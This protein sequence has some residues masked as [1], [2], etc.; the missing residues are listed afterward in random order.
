MRN[1]AFVGV[2][3]GFLTAVGGT[4]HAAASMTVG[5]LKTICTEADAVST[6]A[7]RIYILGVAQGIGIGLAMA[8][9]KA[10]GKRLCLPDDMPSSTLVFAVKEFLGKDLM[11]YPKDKDLDASGFVGGALTAQWP[12]RKP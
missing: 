9:G 2:A 1:I 11:F 8:D 5:D 12:C 7:C 10:E 4:S 6:T 3:A